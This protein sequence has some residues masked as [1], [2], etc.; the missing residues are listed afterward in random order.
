MRGIKLKY[1]LVFCIVIQALFVGCSRNIEIDTGIDPKAEY[2]KITLSSRTDMSVL[3]DDNDNVPDYEN[4]IESVSNN[5]KTDIELDGLRV[6]ETEKS[7]NK[8]EETETVFTEETYKDTAGITD[9]I[10]D[11]EAKEIIS[12]DNKTRSDTVSTESDSVK[13]EKKQNGASDSTD[14]STTYIL[15]KNTKK[16]HFASCSSAKQIKD[17]NKGSDSDR[18]A[19]IAQGYQPCKRCNP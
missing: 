10:A 6:N 3:F 13:S 14:V 15:N 12:N 11:N 9:E 1:I 4:E 19:I 16:F 5:E 17:K 18:D 2:E 8:T 7:E